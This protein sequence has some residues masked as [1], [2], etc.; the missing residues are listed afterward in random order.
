MLGSEVFLR[1][2]A[3]DLDHMGGLLRLGGDL[4]RADD[5]DATFADPAPR[6]THSAFVPAAARTSF[7]LLVDSDLPVGC[8]Q[9][10]FVKDSGDL[11]FVELHHD[12]PPL[13][14]S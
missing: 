2:N 5:E 7:A 9:Q 12:I 1:F 6:G 3:H 8:R 10:A 11:A 13:P 14:P 4:H